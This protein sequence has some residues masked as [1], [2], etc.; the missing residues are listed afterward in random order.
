MPIDGA[1]V[2]GRK[3]EGRGGGE[4]HRSA[5]MSGVQSVTLGLSTCGNNNV[6][7]CGSVNRR[8]KVMCEVVTNRILYDIGSISGRLIVCVNLQI[9]SIEVV[10]CWCVEERNGRRD[11]VSDTS[12]FCFN[13]QCL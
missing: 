8:A 9:I 2:Q 13:I 11:D 1:V 3:A 10:D 5:V 12:V 6:D 7:E 4:S